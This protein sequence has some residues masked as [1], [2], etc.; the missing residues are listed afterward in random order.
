LHLFGS[1]TKA[2]DS[3]FS[4]LYPPDLN[5]S[6]NQ[7]NNQGE[8]QFINFPPSLVDAASEVKSKMREF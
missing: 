2:L 3:F 5:Q 7:S 8:A 6:I 1:P 4:S